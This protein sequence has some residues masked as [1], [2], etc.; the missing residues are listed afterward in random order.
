MKEYRR[1]FIVVILFFLVADSVLAQDD[2]TRQGTGLPMK[3]GENTARGD[4]MNV[5]GRITL[6]T[7]STLTRLP[8][9]KVMIIYAGVTADQSVTND[10]GYYVV[11]NVPR[12]NVTLI[13]EVDSTE[14]VRQP[15]VASAMG[16]PRYDFTIAWPMVSVTAKPGVVS[17]KP[18]FARTE[19]NEDL[20]QKALAAEK[21]NESVKTIGLFNQILGS[22]PKDFVAWTELGT[23]Y[24]KENSLDNAE[25]CYFKAIELK[26]DYFVALLNLGKLYM[27][28]KLSDNAI[29]VLSN[30]V[31]SLPESADAH[32]YLGEAYLQA[33]KGSSAVFHL[34]EAIRLAPIE[35]A[36][37]HLRL[38]ALYD[39]A[40]MKDKAAAEYKIFLGKRPDYQEK[41]KLEKYIADNTRK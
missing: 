32:H 16:N 4:K 5:S 26:K 40:K 33:K 2:E 7:T 31:N 19:K 25:A 24:F 27:N 41:T 15:I 1:L 10:T 8:V 37:I 12:D 20:F 14:V 35:K 28:R 38:A 3:I 11:K 29:L 34:S 18:I 39:A 17:A 23:V 30:A 13:V 22:E 6:D 36:D 9:I 21:A